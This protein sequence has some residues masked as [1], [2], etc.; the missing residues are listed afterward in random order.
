M[1]I[2][3]LIC[4]EIEFDNKKYKVIGVNFEKD[5]IILNVEETG[6]DINLKKKYVLSQRSLNRMEGVHPALQTLIKLG[7]TNSPHDFMIVQGLRTAAYQ[8]ELYQQ[9]RTK[10]GPKVTNCDGYNSKSNH[11][12]KSDGYGHAIDFAI[13]DPTLPN[14]IDWD[15]NKKY[16]EVADHLKKIAKENGINIVWGGDWVKFKDYPH[17]ELV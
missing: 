17:I 3:K 14:K 16:R 13:Y 8:N 15:N 10:P 7:I 1:N 4:T 9:G 2:E 11:Q 12:A 5:N 6:E